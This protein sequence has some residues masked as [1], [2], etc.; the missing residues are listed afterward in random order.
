MEDENNQNGRKNL[1]PPPYKIIPNFGSTKPPF[2]IDL[3]QDE[4]N[5]TIAVTQ[6]NS[7]FGQ[8]Q[9][10]N[11]ARKLEDTQRSGN[12][13]PETTGENLPESN[14][15]Y[16]LIDSKDILPVKPENTFQKQ[17]VSSNKN[18]DLPANRCENCLL[19]HYSPDDPS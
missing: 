18:H 1:I 3:S 6:S 15:G 4:K 11:E 10:Y 12:N 13:I 17:Q 2:H 7:D 5:A 14:L 8:A 9:E 19:S 16:A